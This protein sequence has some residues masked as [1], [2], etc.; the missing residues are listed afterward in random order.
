M[1][2]FGCDC[3]EGKGCAVVGNPWLVECSMIISLSRLIEMYEEC[4]T[5]RACMKDLCIAAVHLWVSAILI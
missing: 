2:A 1:R 4:E 5:L 3:W